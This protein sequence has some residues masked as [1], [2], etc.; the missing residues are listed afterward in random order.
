MELNIRKLQESDW[1]TLTK[2]WNMWPEWENKFPTKELLPENG[3]GGYIVEKSGVPIVAGFL[4]TTNSK[5]GWVEWIVS[6]KDYREH[7]RKDALELL[8]LGIEHVAKSSGYS[9]ILSIARNKGLMNAFKDLKYTVDD[10]P[11]FE[12]SKKIN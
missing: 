4:Y 2:L 10:K 11:S 3:T 7:D 1:D 5:V 12:I 9:I 8:I 6:N